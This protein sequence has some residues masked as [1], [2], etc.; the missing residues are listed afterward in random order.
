[1]FK[2]KIADEM[3][4]WKQSLSFKRKGLI[5]QGLRQVGKTTTVKDF[6]AKEYGNVVY[7]NFKTN[8]SIRSVFDGDL[9]VDRLVIGLSAALPKDRFIPGKTVLIFDEIQECGNARS[10]IKS[11]MEDPQK[12]FDVIAT[13]SLLGLR[14]YNRKPSGGPA[15]GFETFLEMKPM[16]FEEF[17]WAIGLDPKPIDYVKEAFQNHQKVDPAVN[18][19]FHRYFLDYLCVGGMPEAVAAFVQSKDMNQVGQIQRDI[20]KSYQ[21]DFGK[22]LD[23]KENEIIDREELGRIEAVYD[24]IPSQLGKE[25]KKFQYAE[26]GKHARARN[27]RSAIQW[28]VDFGLISLCHNLSALELPLKGNAVDDCFKIYVNDTGLFVAMLE[29][30]SVFSIL[31]GDLG[32]YKGAI[33]ENLVADAF[34]KNSLPLFY[35]AK[36]SGLEIDFV[37]RHQNVLTLIEVKARNGKSKSLKTVLNDTPSYHVKANYKLTDGNLGSDGLIN[38][39]PQYMAFLID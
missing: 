39:V 2:R 31:Q 34:T 10:S 27:Y 38:T 15:T 17:L 28:L 18:E 21:D 29:Q 36:N 23:E 9:D 32:I 8:R 22:H 37:T 20:L 13:G 16:D 19:S 30:G 1:M 5:I 6:A 3:L 33:Y 11:F 25:N 4:A 24:S 14:G 26:I 35:Y 12:R 7:I